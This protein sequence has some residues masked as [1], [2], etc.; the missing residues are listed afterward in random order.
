MVRMEN[1]RLY[2]K[3]LIRLLAP[4][5][6][7]GRYRRV[8]GFLP[9]RVVSRHFETKV[10]FLLFGRKLR[11]RKLWCDAEAFLLHFFDVGRACRWWSSDAV[12]VL[13]R[14]SFV[15]V[16][17]EARCAV[18]AHSPALLAPHFDLD[19]CRL[20]LLD[21]FAAW[22][23]VHARVDDF[24]ASLAFKVLARHHRLVLQPQFRLL[25]TGN[26]LLPKIGERRPERLQLWRLGVSLLNETQV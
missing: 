12:E 22:I 11:R 10:K 9:R 4:V 7:M 2:F 20:L 5:F 18:L 17:M 1:W 21:V 3:R 24:G 16:L 14:L 25:F 6:T 19:R 26:D 13:L 15:L 8:L 23:E